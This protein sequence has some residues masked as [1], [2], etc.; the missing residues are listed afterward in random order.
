SCTGSVVLLESIHA[1]HAPALILLDRADTIIG[2][3]AIVA[4]EVLQKSLP[5]V[6]LDDAGF[7]MALQANEASLSADGILTLR[8]GDALSNIA[9]SAG[10][11]TPPRSQ[12]QLSTQDKRR[13]AGDEGQAVQTAMRI[14]CRVAELQGAPRLIDISRAHIDGC[15]Y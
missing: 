13:L 7:A 4:A 6:V 1:G 5:V 12:L 15:I 14:I 8:G 11:H 10:T 2:L 3:G 9:A